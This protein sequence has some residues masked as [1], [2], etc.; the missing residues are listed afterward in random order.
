[1]SQAECDSNTT[2]PNLY[3]E[4]IICQ[5]N[6]AYQ[7]AYYSR[8]PILHTYHRSQQYLLTTCIQSNSFQRT[9]NIGLISDSLRWVFDTGFGKITCRITTLRWALLQVRPTAF[10]RLIDLIENID[11]LTMY[12]FVYW[13]LRLLIGRASDIAIIWCCQETLYQLRKSVPQIH[14]FQQF[15][16]V[17][18][19]L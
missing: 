7:H 2:T 9:V 16:G 6:A 3:D 11:F 18:I 8:G 19:V 13:L 10:L 14:A 1:M 4:F 12:A 17:S 15:E 5:T